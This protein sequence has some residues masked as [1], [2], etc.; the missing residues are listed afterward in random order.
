MK[1]AL[2]QL[3]EELSK[4]MEKIPEISKYLLVRD[5]LMFSRCEFEARKIW[6]IIKILIPEINV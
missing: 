6:E 1:R 4:E 5:I 2:S 3:Q